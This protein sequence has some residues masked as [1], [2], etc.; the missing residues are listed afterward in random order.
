MFKLNRVTQIG[1]DET[2]GYEVILD[3]EYNVKELLDTVVGIKNEWGYFSIKNGSS[4]EYKWGQLLSNLNEQDF[5][6]KVLK[7]SSSGGWSRMDY[8]VTVY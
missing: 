8:Y 7:V 3:K 5:D 4:C 6:K 2:A 1:G